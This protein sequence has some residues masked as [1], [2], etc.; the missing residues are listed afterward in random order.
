MRI[1]L[2]CIVALLCGFILPTEKKTIFSTNKT[3]ELVK[4]YIEVKYP[5]KNINEFVY[6][7]I[8]RQRLYLIRDSVIV[9]SFPVSTSKYGAGPEK[10]SEK[11]PVGLHKIESKIGNDTPLYGIILGTKYTG[12]IAEIINDSV[13]SSTDDVT[14]R[15]LR[16]KGVEKNV[17][18]GGS[19][20]TYERNIYI[21]GTP[22]EGLIGKAAS[23][24]C[25]RMK[26]KDV[27]ELFDAV[28]NDAY[29]LI[30]NN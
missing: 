10:D 28:K 14:T 7:G 27:I 17:N 15:A 4:L 23:H 25:I 3:A 19:K 2:L 11:T 22:E 8:K 24:G 5:G 12:E 26:N 30:L 29:V 16:L 20:D 13:V 21:H 9:M 1:V 6:I 18:K